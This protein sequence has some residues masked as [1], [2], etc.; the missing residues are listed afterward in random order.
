[1]SDDMLIDTL[2]AELAAGR[3]V[4]FLGPG[5][6]ALCADGSAV[7]ASPLELVGVMT[8]KVSVPHKLKNKLPGAAQYI[9]NFKHRKTLKNLMDTAYAPA[10]TPSPLHLWL[11]A[12]PLPLI[13][14][15]WYDDVMGAALASRSDW[16]RIQGVSQAE[17]RDGWTHAF[18]ADGSRVEA[19]AAEAWTTLLYQP[20]GAVAP[21]GNYIV[22]DSD[23]VEV[24]TEI[25]I[26]TPI[27]E[28]VQQLRSERSFLFL[29]CR[30]DDQLA[31]SWARQISKRSAG[32]HYAVLP[33]EPTKNELRF[34]EEYGIERIELPLAEFAARLT[35]AG[36]IAEP[37]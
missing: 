31:R 20:T 30:F 15:T 18:A 13:V 6:L 11:A 12:Q 8:K 7:P 32:R 35:G 37:A 25:D 10:V 5:L 34:M 17:H 19:G 22:S 3:V 1:M 4:P 33:E 29:G 14:T 21:A 27:P 9:E 26:Q 36:A 28:R 2:R 24:L 16:G 23:Y